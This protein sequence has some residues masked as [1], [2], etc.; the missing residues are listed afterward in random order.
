MFGCTCDFYA[1]KS[2]Y[3][4]HFIGNVAVLRHVGPVKGLYYVSSYHHDKLL[5]GNLKITWQHNPPLKKVKHFSSIMVTDGKIQQVQ[6]IIG[7]GID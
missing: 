4:H 2:V 1:C 7:N 5:L 3:E 6:V